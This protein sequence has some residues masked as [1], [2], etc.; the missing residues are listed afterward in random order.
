MGSIKE[1]AELESKY[2][3][4]SVS[5]REMVINHA[6]S[7]HKAETTFTDPDLVADSGIVSIGFH[8][9]EPVKR[10]LSIVYLKIIPINIIVLDIFTTFISH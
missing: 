1:Q 3:G 7:S 6:I 2:K 8:L 5:A 10:V 4:C 9:S